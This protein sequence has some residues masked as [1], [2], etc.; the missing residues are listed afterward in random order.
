MS[1][2]T[3]KQIRAS[4]P[5]L[6]YEKFQRAT[7]ALGLTVSEFATRAVIAGID[8]AIAERVDELKQAVVAWE[9]VPPSEPTANGS[10]AEP[11]VGRAEK[12]AKVR[13]AELAEERKRPRR[14]TRPPA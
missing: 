13:A 7:E 8:E 11:R 6:V 3:T 14:S 4:V 2:P 1:D 5:F 9:A 12:A 10:V